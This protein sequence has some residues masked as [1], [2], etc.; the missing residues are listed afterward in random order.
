MNVYLA[1]KQFIKKEIINGYTTN[2][3][4]KLFNGFFVRDKKPQWKARDENGQ[5]VHFNSEAIEFTDPDGTIK[6]MT[7]YEAIV[8]Y[9]RNDLMTDS[10]NEE[11][12][13]RFRKFIIDITGSIAAPMSLDRNYAFMVSLS[14][15]PM[16]I[17]KRDAQGRDVLEN[18]VVVKIPCTTCYKEYP[19]YPHSCF[20][21]IEVYPCKT[22]EDLKNQ[23]ELLISQEGYG[24]RWI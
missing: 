10:P 15:V 7:M 11:D 21:H 16:E 9:L 22:Y 17:V 1:D 4:R 19:A 6:T 23:F 2:D 5:I 13:P 24:D 18:G 14:D 20:R 3:G 8:H 12:S